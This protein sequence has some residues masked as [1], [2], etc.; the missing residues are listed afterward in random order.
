MQSIYRPAQSQNWFKID[1]SSLELRNGSALAVIFC[2]IIHCLEISVVE[3]RSNHEHIELLP[4][5]SRTRA[6]LFRFKQTIN[7]KNNSEIL[8]FFQISAIALKESAKSLT[9]SKTFPCICYVFHASK[10]CYTVLH[11]DVSGN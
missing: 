5:K 11:H 10:R 4:N 7:D 6:D 9:V 8:S 1:K 2:V 3:R